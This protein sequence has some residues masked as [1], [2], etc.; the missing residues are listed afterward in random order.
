MEHH[1]HGFDD[2]SSSEVVLDCFGARSKNEVIVVDT[3]FRLT[4]FCRESTVSSTHITSSPLGC[5][6]K[7]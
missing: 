2:G 4:G 6:E 1:Q 5:D 7:I 3:V